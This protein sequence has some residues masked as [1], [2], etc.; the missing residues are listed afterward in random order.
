MAEFLRFTGTDG[1][2]RA[3][4]ADSVRSLA[5]DLDLPGVVQITLSDGSWFAAKGSVESI[6]AERSL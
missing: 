4:R 1:A 2:E 3:V 6:M 5:D